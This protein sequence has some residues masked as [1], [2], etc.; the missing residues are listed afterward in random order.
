MNKLNSITSEKRRRFWLAP[1]MVMMSLFASACVSSTI[2][3]PVPTA[4]ITTSELALTQEEREIQELR[5][6]GIAQIRAKAH[7]VPINEAP[8]AYGVPRKGDV[9]LL[10]AEEISAKTNA[11]NANSAQ[12]DAQLPDVELLQKQQKIAE[13]QRKAATHYQ[14]TVKKIENN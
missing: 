14:S 2:E 7:A 1:A 9:A 3:A 13:M 12:V 4:A 10:T 5:A 6:D 8:P 11:L